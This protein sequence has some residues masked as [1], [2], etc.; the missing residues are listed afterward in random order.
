MD[1]VLNDK[2]LLVDPEIRRYRKDSFCI[3]HFVKSD[4]V[5]ADENGQKLV[6][7]GTLVD[8][9]GAICKVTAKGIEGTPVGITHDTVDVTHS[10]QQVAIYTRGHLQ[11]KLLNLHGQEYSDTIG[12]AIES[13]LPEI[14][15]YPRPPKASAAGA[16]TTVNFDLS[17][18]TGTLGLDK[19]GTG[20]TTASEA[21]S[22]LLESQPLS[23][24]N[25]GTGK[26]T[27]DEA[28][29]ALLKN[30]PLSIENGGTG[31]SDK[32]KALTNLGAQKASS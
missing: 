21:L 29:K 17:K 26:N 12:T 25:G 2:K 27:A 18:A 20:K 13:A 30:Q 24:E 31:A 22:A 16:S 19:G 15:I 7:I 1:Y 23:V 3:S 6:P 10:D 32:E 28:L 8:K 14:H 4:G 5:E 9:D 11:G